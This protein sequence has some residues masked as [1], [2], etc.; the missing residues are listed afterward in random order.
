MTTQDAIKSLIL[1]RDQKIPTGGF[2]EACLANDLKEAFGRADETSRENLFEI[3]SFLY[4]SMPRDF[5]GSYE[6]IK[7][8]L[9]S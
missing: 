5:W 9:N 6:N 8:H 4:N 7:K 1:Y 3:V 2:L